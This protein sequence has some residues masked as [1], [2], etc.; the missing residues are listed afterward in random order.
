MKVVYLFW[1]REK[2]SGFILNSRNRCC[3]YTPVVPLFVNFPHLILSLSKI[4][5]KYTIFFANSLWMHYRFRD[6][7]WIHYLSR[8]FTMN[9]LSSSR[10]QKNRLALSR[11]YYKYAFYITN[12]ISRIQKFTIV[13]FDSIP[14]LTK[15]TGIKWI[16]K[17]LNWFQNVPKI[18]RDFQWFS[19]N[20]KIR[21]NSKFRFSNS[22]KYPSIRRYFL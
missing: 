7:I 18:T 16:T 11:F 20:S 2:D 19:S 15:L 14:I 1:M 12:S 13:Q 8:V 3:I 9:A 17:F 5:D 22:Q 4:N 6:F 21:N 10:I